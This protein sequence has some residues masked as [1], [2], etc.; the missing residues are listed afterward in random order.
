MTAFSPAKTNLMSTFKQG[1]RVAHRNR[2]EWG[3]GTVTLAEPASH[4]GA[5]CQRLTIRFDRAGA[6][7]LSTA[8]APLQAFTGSKF[9]EPS[10]SEVSGGDQSMYRQSTGNSPL[11]LPRTS[12]SSD[13]EPD[14]LLSL[15]P[16]ASEKRE[17]LLRVP[18][19]ATDPF[20]TPRKRLERTL[21]LF[22]FSAHGGSL[23][24]WAAMQTQLKDP[25]SAFNRHELED[26]FK[27]F[28]NR[29]EQHLR[30]VLREVRKADPGA[31]EELS[32]TAVPAARQA[33]IRANNER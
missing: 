22:R 26:A 20:V 3:A 30:T 27:W 7:V 5:A 1:D 11:G 32:K 25:L 9:D 17:M 18:D 13:L 4:N 10:S 2:P 33:L 8:L 16:T 12:V 21:A 15:K 29:L 28:Q 24:D 23:L 31:I 19:D 14:P 6:K